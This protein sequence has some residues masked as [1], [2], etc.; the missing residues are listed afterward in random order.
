[1]CLNSYRSGS[2]KRDYS[3][4]KREVLSSLT[5]I[6]DAYKQWQDTGTTRAAA[7]STISKN[8][9]TP[10]EISQ[11]IIDCMKLKQYVVTSHSS[12]NVAVLR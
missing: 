6:E 4:V 2:E 1:V 12:S 7:T 8:S 11:V 10:E 9:A 3:S 5:K